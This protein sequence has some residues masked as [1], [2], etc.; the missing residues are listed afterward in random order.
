MGADPSLGGAR[1]GN[2]R[3]RFATLLV[4]CDQVVRRAED[5][6]SRVSDVAAV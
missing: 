3:I 1:L 4:I 2:G 6:P 5:L